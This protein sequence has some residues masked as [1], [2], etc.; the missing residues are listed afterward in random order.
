MLRREDIDAAK[1]RIGTRTFEQ[2][3]YKQ[4]NNPL[5][6]KTGLYSPYLPHCS[7][8][9][10]Y[11][12]FNR[13]QTTDINIQGSNFYDFSYHNE[14]RPVEGGAE[15]ETELVT[16]PDW[17]VRTD[18]D[19]SSCGL[20]SNQSLYATT[21][22]PRIWF[23]SNIPLK[24]IIGI[25][26]NFRNNGTQIKV[27]Y[28]DG[29][30]Y[31][32]V[33]PN[34]DYIPES[35]REEETEYELS[36]TRDSILS[37]SNNSDINYIN[38]IA[39]FCNI[40]T[41]QYVI[42]N[43]DDLLSREGL[44]KSCVIVDNTT[45]LKQSNKNYPITYKIELINATSTER[46]SFISLYRN[47][48][49]CINL[50]NE[51]GR[52]LPNNI[53]QPTGYFSI[54]NRGACNTNL[55]IKNDDNLYGNYLSSF[56][57]QRIA[58]WS[59][60]FEEDEARVYL[61]S[62]HKIDYYRLYDDINNNYCNS[63]IDYYKKLAQIKKS[64]SRESNRI[65]NEINTYNNR[66]EKLQEDLLETEDEE[67]IAIINKE[68]KKLQEH[69][70]ALRIEL[71]YVGFIG[72]MGNDRFGND[73]FSIGQYSENGKP[74]INNVRIYHQRNAS[75]SPKYPCYGSK[76]INV[77]ITANYKP[78]KLFYLSNPASGCGLSVW[79]HKEVLEIQPIEIEGTYELEYT[80]VGYRYASQSMEQNF[81]MP[82]GG[83]G[84]YYY[85]IVLDAEPG[86]IDYETGSMRHSLSAPNLLFS[87]GEY[88]YTSNNRECGTSIVFDGV[89]ANSY[90]IVGGDM[91]S[92]VEAC[93]N[94]ISLEGIHTFGVDHYCPGPVYIITSCVS[95]QQCYEEEVLVVDGWVSLN[96]IPSSMVGTGL[97]CFG[98]TGLTANTINRTNKTSTKKTYQDCV[99]L[100]GE[101][102][103]KECEC[104]VNDGDA[105]F[106]IYNIRM[107]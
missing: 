38:T 30:N 74:N 19:K 104:Y 41:L 14:E 44:F 15:G 67:Q 39:A 105:V 34:P 56:Q 80:G 31:I 79:R 8:F 75:Y 91:I 101:G 65:N 50:N 88:P 6:S 48:L 29:N 82:C 36:E 96:E 24:V 94:T 20:S 103:G 89:G 18:S 70:T 2:A 60:F 93:N 58:N 87:S 86:F 59:D 107:Q 90:E 26:G 71:E 73:F 66:I 7:C 92:S 1:T 27:Y 23:K 21:Q 69:S 47:T 22:N 13:E 12:D 97:K 4:S 16:L 77:D 64:P 78:T 62:Q 68:I 40:P 28:G 102:N 10:R 45:V 61:T 17:E 49:E 51:I 85:R 5:L 100:D 83:T 99:P 25:L 81:D 32:L 37:F 43:F 9:Y 63:C 42:I 52:Y 3:I 76:N 35:E 54:L 95:N 84:T 11:D 57:H 72:S 46:I 53:I 33:K 55:P 106:T 98:Y